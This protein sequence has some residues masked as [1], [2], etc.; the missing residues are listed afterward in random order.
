M[1]YKALDTYWSQYASTGGIVRGCAAWLLANGHI[2]GVVAV[3]QGPNPGE[4]YWS[5]TDDPKK[6]ARSVYDATN[7]SLVLHSL[8]DDEKKN[9]LFIGTP[10]QPGINFKY[11]I[12]IVCSGAKR[13]DPERLVVDYRY[14][15][16]PNNYGLLY[17]DGGYVPESKVVTSKIKS[18]CRNCLHN[19]T[20]DMIVGDLHGTPYNIVQTNNP[21]FDEYIKTTKHKEFTEQMFHICTVDD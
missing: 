1:Y 3:I 15:I 19:Y 5:T 9:L 7:P 2:D 17:A 14:G 13:G 21:L 4:F 11:R 16:K 6:L 8:T 20:G 12:T 18:A 10:C